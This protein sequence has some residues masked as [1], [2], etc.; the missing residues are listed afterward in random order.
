[1]TP[2]PHATYVNLWGSHF[3]TLERPKLI[4]RLLH[5]LIAAVEERDSA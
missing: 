4:T 2:L 5:D 3:L 1:M